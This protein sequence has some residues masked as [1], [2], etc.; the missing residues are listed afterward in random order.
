MRVF[1]FLD[2]DHALRPEIPDGQEFGYRLIAVPT[3][4]IQARDES[5]KVE[6]VTKP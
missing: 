1:T 2:D 4:G 3:G 6:I 5:G